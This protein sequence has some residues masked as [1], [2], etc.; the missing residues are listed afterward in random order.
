MIRIIIQAIKLNAAHGRTALSGQIP[1]SEGVDHLTGH[2]ATGVACK[3][4]DEAGDIP[5]SAARP[6][7]VSQLRMMVN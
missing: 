7:S 4:E 6:L 2:L 1:A 3:A 5:I